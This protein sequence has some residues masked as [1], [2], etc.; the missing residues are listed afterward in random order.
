MDLDGVSPVA[1]HNLPDGG[2]YIVLRHRNHLGV[3]TAGTTHLTGKDTASVDFTKPTTLTYGTKAQ[4]NLGNIMAMWAG[5]ANGDGTIKY[6]GASNDKIFILSKVGLTTP[7]N[8]LVIYDAADTNL[9]G[10][11]KYNG[12]GNDKNLILANV[13]LITSNNIIVQQLPQ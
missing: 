4:K 5:N 8:V 13:G 6:N 3:M 12:A 2:Y 1:F 11:V 10:S 9:D 7:N